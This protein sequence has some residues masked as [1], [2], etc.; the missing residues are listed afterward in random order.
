V[1]TRFSQRKK[2]G[3][4]Y[5]SVKQTWKTIRSLLKKKI[6]YAVYYGVFV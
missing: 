4:L 2:A 1:Y 3:N 6:L 5:L